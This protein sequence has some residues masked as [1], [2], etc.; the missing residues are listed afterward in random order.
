M[1]VDWSPEAE[2]HVNA[3]LNRMG[4]ENPWAAEKW[5]NGLLKVVNAAASF[6][7]LGREYPGRNDPRLREVFHGKYR[8]IYVTGEDQ[9]EIVAVWHG[10]RRPPGGGIAGELDDE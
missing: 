6:P 5:L 10:A 1:R 2:G 9:I 4:V 8:V 7:N 3:I